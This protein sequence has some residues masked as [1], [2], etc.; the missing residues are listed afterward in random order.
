MPPTPELT[1]PPPT[2]A[3]Q[4]IA[5]TPAP[6]PVPPTPT[7]V[8]PTPTVQVPTLQ[9]VLGETQDQGQLPPAVG[10]WTFLEVVRPFMFWIELALALTVT[11]LLVATLWLRRKQHPV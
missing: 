3:P 5:E 2:E 7:P 9:A 4:V 1:E 8:P 6:T 11:M 10:P